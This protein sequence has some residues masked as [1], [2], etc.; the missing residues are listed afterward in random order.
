MHG[1]M[2]ESGE[3]RGKHWVADLMQLNPNKA[4]RGYKTPRR[5]AGQ[6]S[7]GD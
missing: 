1:D 5:I 2:C 3:T 6:P 4:V 7:L